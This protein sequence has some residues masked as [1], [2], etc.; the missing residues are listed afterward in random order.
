MQYA[1]GQHLM[2]QKQ[3]EINK[4]MGYVN[5]GQGTQ[6]VYQQLTNFLV[7]FPHFQVVVES[8]ALPP[9]IPTPVNMFILKGEVQTSPIPSD[10]FKIKMILI[11][12]FP[13]HAPRVYIDQQ[14]DRRIID[15]KQ[16]LHGNNEVVIPY[17]QQWNYMSSNLKDLMS[18]LASVLKADPPKLPE[19]TPPV[20]N[21]QQQQLNQGMSQMNISQT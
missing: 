9:Q 12:S 3:A 14:L 20:Q 19:G 6:I 17:L 15:Q 4:W 7:G 16:Y 13:Y 21:Q 5:Y 2:Q 18:F 1:S 10:K 8:M 11:P